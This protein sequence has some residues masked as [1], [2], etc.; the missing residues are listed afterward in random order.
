MKFMDTIKCHVCGLV[1]YMQAKG[2]SSR[3]FVGVCPA[4]EA[5]DQLPL[6]I[7]G[8]SDATQKDES[9]RKPKVIS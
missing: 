7:G 2:K 4:C 8:P 1:E 5:K 6:P 9:A 3:S